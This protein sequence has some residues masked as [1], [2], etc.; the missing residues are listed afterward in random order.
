MV[1]KDFVKDLGFKEGLAVGA[2]LVIGLSLLS[3]LLGMRIDTTEAVKWWDLMTAFGTVGTAIAA[4]WFS[5]TASEKSARDAKV[6]SQLARQ[7]CQP[8]LDAL[9]GGLHAGVSDARFLAL[10][11]DGETRHESRLICIRKL[12]ALLHLSE[13]K[14]RCERI[15]Q[16]NPDE[17]DF[18]ASVVLAARRV[19]VYAEQVNSFG[20]KQPNGGNIVSFVLLQEICALGRLLEGKAEGED[21][22][23]FE[24]ENYRG[25]ARKLGIEEAVFPV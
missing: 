15:A 21:S 18:L 12:P 5:L 14:E 10:I 17:A 13:C 25:V 23:Q 11:N 8:E 2:A 24:I 19:A 1:W 22:K 6:A 3:F 7:L 9:M 20:A 16:G 4:V